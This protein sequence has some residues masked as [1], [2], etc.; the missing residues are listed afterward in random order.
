MVVAECFPVYRW[1]LIG[2]SFR[3]EKLIDAFFW[4]VEPFKKLRIVS[5]ELDE[6]LI[7]EVDGP[8]IFILSILCSFGVSG[9]QVVMIG[10][11]LYLS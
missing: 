3:F 8:F 9:L 7:V 11:L 4:T 10:V 1:H 2:M 6:V 5:F